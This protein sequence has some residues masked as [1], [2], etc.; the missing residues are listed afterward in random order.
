MNTDKEWEKWGQRDPYFGVL[1]DPKFRS[2]NLDSGTK[3]EFFATG[4]QHVAR[5]MGKIHKFIDSDFKPELALDF[6]CGTG[7]V[8]VAMAEIARKVVGIDI[9]DSMLKEAE[10]NCRAL[11]VENTEFYKSDDRLSAIQKFKFDFIHTFIVLQ[12]IPVDR[13]RV[14]FSQL[15]HLMK[16]GAVGAIHLTYA[17]RVFSANQGLK[18]DNLSTRANG[19]YRSLRGIARNIVYPGKDPRMQMNTHGL[20]QLYFML[21]SGGVEE[22]FTEFTD[23]GGVLGVFLYFRKGPKN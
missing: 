10:A 9:S 14:I 22:M 18:P 17:D 8:T 20:N 12:H 19:I 4:G 2:G 11:N 21:Q 1:T 6:G 13:V 5:V 7:R 16:D 23:H 15:L 3:A